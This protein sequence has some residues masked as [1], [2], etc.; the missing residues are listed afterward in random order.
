MISGN[1]ENEKGSEEEL[2]AG[3]KIIERGKKI[4]G[5]YCTRKEIDGEIRVSLQIT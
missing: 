4:Y 1:S 3:E 2:M 5:E